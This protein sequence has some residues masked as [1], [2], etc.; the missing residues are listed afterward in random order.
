MKNLSVLKVFTKVEVEGRVGYIVGDNEGFCKNDFSD[1]KYDV[2]F[3]NSKKDVSDKVGIHSGN[4][5]EKSKDITV[6]REKLNVLDIKESIYILPDLTQIT[7][8][9]KNAYVVGNNRDN[10]DLCL[11]NLNYY[12]KYA[13][14]VTEVTKTLRECPEAF[15]DEVIHWQDIEGVWILPLYSK[16][17]YKGQVGFIVYSDEETSEEDLSDLNYFIKFEDKLE[18]VFKDNDECWYDNSFLHYDIRPV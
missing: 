2:K 7:V 18:D 12:I 15:Y 16:V 5:Y 9:G 1:L 17:E 6:S 4:R 10:L 11:K 8:S 14:D 13:D 3:G